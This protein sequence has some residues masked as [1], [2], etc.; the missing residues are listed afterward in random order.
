[1]RLVVNER[2][3]L[4]RFASNA[5]K[6]RN[7][8]TPLLARHFYPWADGIVTVS[9]GVREDLSE[10]IRM[11]RDRIDVIYN[12][13]VDR[14]DVLDRARAPLEHPWFQP[15]EPPVVL[16]VGRLHPQ[17]DYPTLI[18]AFAELRQRRDA[19]LVILGEGDRRPELEA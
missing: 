17:K 19:R 13:S 8:M 10:A 6:F 16:A 12:P 2:N 1:V 18:R 11:P 14:A 3:T 4:S 7:R 5:A 9:E 15:G